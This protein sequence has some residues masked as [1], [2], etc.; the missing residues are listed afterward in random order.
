MTVLKMALKRSET[1]RKGHKIDHANGE[2]WK[3]GNVHAIY[4]QRFETLRKSRSRYSHVHISKFKE[5]LKI[6]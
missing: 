2:R 1:L 3:A 6:F 5:S 4:D